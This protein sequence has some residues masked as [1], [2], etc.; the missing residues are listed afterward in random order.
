MIGDTIKP[1]DNPFD[2]DSKFF[3]QTEVF[4][5][6]ENS[7]H[8]LA[9]KPKKTSKKRKY[10]SPDEQSVFIEKIELEKEVLHQKL[11]NMKKKEI[12]IDLKIRKIQ[13]CTGQ[14]YSFTIGDE[15]LIVEEDLEEPK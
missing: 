13:A 1:V 15:P 6:D 12:L 4:M 8:S 5:V 11:V 7:Q 9:E 14:D 10:V 2:F 3:S